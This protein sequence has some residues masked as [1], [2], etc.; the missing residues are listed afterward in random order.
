MKF[1]EMGQTTRDLITHAQCIECRTKSADAAEAYSIDSASKRYILYLATDIINE[2]VRYSLNTSEAE[3]S[4]TPEYSAELYKN[5]AIAMDMLIT[6]AAK[7][8]DADLFSAAMN[9][10]NEK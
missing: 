5:A 7:R 2:Y 6:A 4:K 9:V 10:K 8:S 1:S 3:S